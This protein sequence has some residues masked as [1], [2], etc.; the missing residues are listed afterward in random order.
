M[1]IDLNNPDK[2]D[3]DFA[4]L[5]RRWPILLQLWERGDPTSEQVQTRLKAMVIFMVERY[6]RS[7]DASRP[8][9]VVFENN[10]ILEFPDS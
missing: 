7:D 6:K 5:L 4:H 3:M 10:E 1:K 2:I 9:E 8:A